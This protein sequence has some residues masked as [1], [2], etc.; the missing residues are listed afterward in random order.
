MSTPD[1]LQVLRAILAK[2]GISP[3]RYAE[4]DL[5]VGERVTRDEAKKLLGLI[6]EWA[7]RAEY[8]NREINLM[9]RA[10]QHAGTWD[11]FCAD[12]AAY[13]TYRESNGG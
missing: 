7:H 13:T 8:E 12:Y 6:A 1:E 3:E 10:M 9:R 4:I 5:G 11:Q 2:K